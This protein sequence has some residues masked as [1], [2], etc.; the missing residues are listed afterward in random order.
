MNIFLNVHYGNTQNCIILVNDFI[1]GEY[2]ILNATGFTRH[3]FD[4]NNIIVHKKKSI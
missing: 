3:A 1:L 4:K 2:L